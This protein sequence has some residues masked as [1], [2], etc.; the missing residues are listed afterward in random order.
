MPRTERR[1][2]HR[3]R[4]APWGLATAIAAG[5]AAVL[6]F[7]LAVVQ[8][9]APITPQPARSAGLA[10]GT[11]APTVALPAT[12]GGTLAV[13]RLRGSKAVV[14]FYESAG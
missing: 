1:T 13:D 10:V 8:L 2:R 14:Y 12:T 3:Q 11:P 9:S 5:V 4:R 7:G 6:G